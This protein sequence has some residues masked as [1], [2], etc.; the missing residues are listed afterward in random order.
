[1]ALIRIGEALHCHIPT[2]RASGRRWLQGDALDREAGERHL[3]ELV[4]AQAGAGANYLDVNVDDFLIDTGLGRQNA[5][6]LMEHILTLIERHGRGIPPC[7][8][9]SDPQVLEHGLIF[10]HKLTGGRA[11]PLV[12]SVTATRLEVLGMRR[13]LPFSAVCMLLERVGD[14]TGFT[15]IAGPEVY[16]ETAR[17]LFD[18]AVAAGFAADEIFFDPTVGPLGADVVGYTRRT[19]EGIRAI[20]ADAQM[21][22]VH[23]C[24]GLSNCSDGLPRRLAINRA[25]LN[26]A[27]EYGVDAAILDAVQMSGEDKADSK[28]LALIRRIVEDQE[29]DALS[30]LVDFAQGNPRSPAPARRKPLP[31]LFGKAL[32]DPSGPPIYLLEMA[33]SEDGVDQILELA[34]EARNTPF[35][36]SITDTPGGHRVPGPDTIGLEVGRIMDRQPIVNLSCKSSDRVGLAQRAIGMYRQGLRHFFAVTGDY[37]F[38]GRANFDLDAV[39]LLMAL[40]CLRRGLDFPSLMPRSGGG[41]EGLC[42]GAAVSPFKYE[43]PDLW[44]QYLKLWKKRQA[45]AA[46]F[47]TQLGYDPKKFHELQLYLKT[48]GMEPVPLIGMAYYLTPQFLRILSHAHVAGVVIP[49]DLKKKYQSRLLSKKER[50]RVQKLGF[51]DL[52]EYQRAFSIRRAALLADL[53]VRGLGYRGVD[54]AGFTQMADALE[55]LETIRQ[56]EGRPWRES[57]EEFS[58][59]DEQGPMR[60][61]PEKAFYLFPEGEDGLLKEGPYQQAQRHG[62][63]ESS[64]GMDLVHKLFF[65]K[66]RGLYPLLEGLVSG[67]ADSLRLRLLTQAEQAVKSAT[68]GCEMCG[69]CRI[70]DLFYRC[71]EPTAGCAKHQL[72]GPCGGADLGG[73]C[74]VHPERRCYWNQVVETALRTGRLNDLYPIQFPKDPALQHSSSWRNEVLGLRAEA[75]DLGRPAH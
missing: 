35:T 36:F 68:L 29:A 56:L 72:N 38:E 71:P 12:N 5:L 19:F 25:Y 69:D 30:L 55:V 45:G 50:S 67:P 15:D 6:R 2:V 64:T 18:K 53:L 75:L 1:M 42:A 46:Y 21:A 39:T 61:A 48:S 11:K 32:A 31:D 57:L 44:G 34:E 52:A 73:N 23:V 3:L 43:E 7:I 59:G 40:Q 49:E 22:G 33:P 60:L 10:Y 17:Y 41:L 26:L 54:L 74:E 65:R 66:D 47:I 14:Q 16:H 58:A 62:Y 70:A 37:S 24:L 27:M 4:G 9:S 8:D 28:I 13:Q 63:Q 20:R 51:G